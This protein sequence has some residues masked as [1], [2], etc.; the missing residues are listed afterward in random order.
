MRLLSN[1]ELK[2]VSG[3][4]FDG[5]KP[6]SKPPSEPTKPGPT[7]DPYVPSDDPIKIFEEIGEAI[8]NPFSSL[9]EAIDEFFEWGI[10]GD[11]P[12]FDADAAAQ[13]LGCAGA[14]DASCLAGVG[15]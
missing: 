6:P 11:H 5:D 10:Y 9:G 4:L 7:S 14:S 12:P 3:G 15:D 8:E 13:G 2:Q 1:V